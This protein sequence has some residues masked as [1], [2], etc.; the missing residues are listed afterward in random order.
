MVK[1]RGFS[2]VPANELKSVMKMVT[3][4]GQ[5]LQERRIEQGYT[6]ESLAEKLNISV[7]TIKGIEQ[8]I[9]YP[10]MPTFV[11][12]AKALKLMINLDS[13]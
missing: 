8:G 6:Q 11:R 13:Q 12:I 10:S 7:N 5:Q 1:K 3:D 2:K 4:I 9:R